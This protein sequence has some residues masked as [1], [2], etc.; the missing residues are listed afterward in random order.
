MAE[1]GPRHGWALT[2]LAHD[3]QRAMFYRQYA[4]AACLEGTLR[5]CFLRIGDR[6]AA[7]QLAVEQRG[8]FWLLRAGYDARFADCSPGLILTRDTIRYAAEA[9]LTSYEFL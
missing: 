3:P 6:T 7:M 2:P 8:A 1:Q 5:V 9:G 4:R